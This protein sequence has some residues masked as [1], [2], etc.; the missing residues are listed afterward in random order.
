MANALRGNQ[1]FYDFYD[2]PDKVHELLNISADA[3]IWLE[4]ELRNLVKPVLGG[5][6]SGSMWF[7]GGAP[8]MSE[9]ATDLCSAD[10]YRK[11]GRAYTQKVI[12]ALGGAYIHHHMKGAHV[13]SEIAKL[14]NLKTL[15]ISWDPNCPKP[16][17]NLEKI[18]GWNG[19]LPL[20]TR[21][22]VEEV[23]E[24]IEEIKLGRMVLMLN[25]TNLEEARDVTKFIRKHSKI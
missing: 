21:C 22:T 3:I 14:N 11:F 17:E 25:V 18:Y 6:V 19:D 8:Y 15:E 16:I 23:Y 4:K 5:T 2:D 7:P 13:H 12:D 10:I 1:L 24:H 20:M 9:D